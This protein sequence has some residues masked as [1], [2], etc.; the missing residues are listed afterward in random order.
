MH[1]SRCRDEVREKEWPFLD[2]QAL[3][4]IL[5]TYPFE[6][7]LWPRIARGGQKT[8]YC[9]CFRASLVLSLFALFVLN[10]MASHSVTQAGVQWH[11]L[12]S[13]QPWPPRLKQFSCLSFLSSWN[14]RHAPPHLASFCI[15][16][17]DGV[18]PCWPG[19]FRT[20]DLR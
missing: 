2:I 11:N 10:E 1:V 9:D 5:P 17:R 12:G 13:L 4:C 8:P 15:F 20:P 14:Y 6:G 19:W 3:R 16:S 18:S 7:D